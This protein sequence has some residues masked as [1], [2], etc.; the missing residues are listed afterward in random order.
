V[1]RRQPRT[2]HRLQP[3]IHTPRAATSG[4]KISGGDAEAD[5]D[6]A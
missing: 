4:A 5:P 3:E 1:D 2:Y 6:D